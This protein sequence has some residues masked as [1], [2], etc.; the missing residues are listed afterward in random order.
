MSGDKYV[1]LGCTGILF[2]VG[3]AVLSI[4]AIVAHIYQP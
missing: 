4:A 2:V 3:L 1:G